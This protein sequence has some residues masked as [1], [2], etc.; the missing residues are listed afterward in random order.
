MGAKEPEFVL[1]V[2][3]DTPSSAISDMLK[4]TYDHLYIRCINPLIEGGASHWG[5]LGVFS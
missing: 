4:L 5:S 3:V 2:R 1:L